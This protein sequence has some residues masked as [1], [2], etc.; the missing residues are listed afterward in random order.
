VGAYRLAKILINPA[1]H[2]GGA[3]AGFISILGFKEPPLFK[4]G[5]RPFK[6]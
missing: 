3:E 1:P 6:D 2:L 5:A 4:K